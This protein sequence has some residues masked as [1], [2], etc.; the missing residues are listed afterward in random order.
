[1]KPTMLFA[2][3]M[4]TSIILMTSFDISLSPTAPLS[5]PASMGGNVLYVCPAANSTWD[6]LAAGFGQFTKPI[7]IGFLFALML[8]TFSW[9]WA[10]YQNLLK[11]KF[12][13]DAFKQPWAFTK[14]LFWAM[15]I[16]IMLIFTPNHFR[17]VHVDGAQGN[18]VLCESNSPAA[19]AEPANLVHP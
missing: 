13:R 10:L 14:L 1:M 11:D 7:I 19:R 3:I 8:L 5:I 4:L 16:I 9:S 18:W 2:I 15:I 6:V 17:S 12:V